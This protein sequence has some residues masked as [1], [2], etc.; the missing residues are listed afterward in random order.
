VEN[1][2]KPWISALRSSQDRLAALVEPLGPDRVTAPSMAAGW[3][4]AQVLSHLGSQAEIFTAIL[5]AALAQRPLPGPE[6][7]PPVWD[8]WN[9]RSAVD[10]VADGVAANEGFVRR[11]EE[12][13]DAQL[14]G[15]A[16]AVFGMDLDAAGFLRMRLSEHALH[17]WDVAAALDP[18]AG[19]SPEAVDLLVDTLPE[20][21]RRVGKAQDAPIRIRMVTSDPSRDLALVVDDE[22]RIGRFESGSTDGVLR[23]P[24]EALVR[25]VYGRLDAEHTPTVELD[26]PDLTLDTLRSVFPGF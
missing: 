9:A 1:D 26:A 17:T 24:A 3:S 10:Q 18:T 4:V 8:A 2:P 14:E 19:V 7:F 12:L 11:V 5:D 13:S 25:L 21:A 22:V 20:M 6:A 15:L 23:L 16:F